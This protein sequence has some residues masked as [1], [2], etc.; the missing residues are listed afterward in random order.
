MTLYLEL[1][2]SA[3][4]SIIGRIVDSRQSRMDGHVMISNEITNR[5]EADKMLKSWARL[6]R[7]ALDEAHGK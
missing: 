2:D 5:A 7:K 6:L 3:T 1:Y 4:S